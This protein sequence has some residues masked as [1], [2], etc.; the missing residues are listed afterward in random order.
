MRKVPLKDVSGA[1][2]HILITAENI[3]S[4]LGADARLRASEARFRAL[5]STLFEGI[6]VRD[7]LGR[8]RRPLA[9]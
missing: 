2:T 7:S 5:V 4:R 6:L 1:V 8:L 3:T 9:M